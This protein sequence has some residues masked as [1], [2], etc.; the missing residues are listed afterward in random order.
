MGR[1]D[2]PP[3]IARRV[4]DVQV[5]AAL[6]TVVAVAANDGDGETAGKGTG[7]VSIFPKMDLRFGGG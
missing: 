2:V 3:R 5:A 4:V 6:A 7:F 1:A